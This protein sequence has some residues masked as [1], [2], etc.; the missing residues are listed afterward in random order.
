MANSSDASLDHAAAMQAF[1]YLNQVQ[2]VPGRFLLWDSI[3]VRVAEAK[4]L[5]MAR[6]NYLDH[7]TP[8]GLGINILM[9]QAGY[10]LPVAWINPPRQNFFESIA[11]GTPTDD[12]ISVIQRLLAD[13]PHRTHLLGLDPFH[14]GCR[15]CGIGFARTSTS[16]YAAYISV[17]I[18]KHN[19]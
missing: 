2:Q 12:G 15:D 10:V 7:V 9:S 11:G 6:R 14:A 5:D 4:A 18:A 8:E 17:I 19:F 1:A 16:T 13:P 3:L